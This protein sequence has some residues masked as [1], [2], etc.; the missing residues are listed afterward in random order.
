[1]RTLLSAFLVASVGLTLQAQP[2]NDTINNPIHFVFLNTGSARAKTKDMS[3]EE[4][5]KMQAAHVGNF[6]TQFDS[7]KI[8]AAGPLGDNGFIRGIVIPNAETAEQV[9]EIF[10]PDPFVQNGILDVEAHPWLVDISRF[11]SPKVPFQLARHTLHV[12]GRPGQ[13][14]LRGWG[15]VVADEGAQHHPAVPRSG[16]PGCWVSCWRIHATT[17]S[18]SPWSWDAKYASTQRRI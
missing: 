5:E 12:A 17:S 16:P 10:K 3:K 4:L 6:G 9:K 18:A 13:R 2:A 11:G 7:G 8:F 1:M 14:R 15:V